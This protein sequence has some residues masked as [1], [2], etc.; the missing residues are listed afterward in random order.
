MNARSNHSR[1]AD[2]ELCTCRRDSQD[3]GNILGALYLAM[4]FLGIINSRTVLPPTSYERSVWRAEAM[5]LMAWGFLQGVL[6]TFLLTGL[7]SLEKSRMHLRAVLATHKHA[8]R[9]HLAHNPS[10]QLRY[11]HQDVT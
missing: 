7:L 8:W 1:H 5:L 11:L 3:V 9:P 6:D 10:L 4:L 2:A